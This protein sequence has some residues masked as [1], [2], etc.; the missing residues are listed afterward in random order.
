MIRKTLLAAVLA[1]MTAA[2][3]ATCKLETTSHCPP[4]VVVQPEQPREHWYSNLTGVDKRKHFGV[5]FLAG[6]I[7]ED[8]KLR[9]GNNLSFVEK[10]L[11][12]SVPGLTKEIIDGLTPGSKFSRN[13]LLFDVMGA[14][15]GVAFQGF[16]IAPNISNKAV[17]VGFN[18][19]F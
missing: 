8:Q 5:S 14:A 19:K 6:M 10:T 7:V 2:A 18:T 16:V 4:P 17:F 15:S 12:A 9:F 3:G 11:I 13:D 1:I